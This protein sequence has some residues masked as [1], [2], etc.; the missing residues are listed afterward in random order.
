[1]IHKGYTNCLSRITA[2][3]AILFIATAYSDVPNTNTNP[4]TSLG[5]IASLSYTGSVSPKFAYNLLGEGG[6]YHLRAN[7]TVGFAL[8]D[9]NRFKITTEYLAQDITY[10]FFSGNSQQWVHQT[11]VGAGYQHD[12]NMRF[13]PQFDVSGYY[14]Y[15]PSK[16]LSIVSGLYVNPMGAPINFIDNRRI[17]GSA[18]S[19]GEAGFSLHPWLSAK[20]GIY[21]N[22]D[23]VDYDQSY[24]A[25]NQDAI[26]LGGTA[27]YNQDLT[28]HVTLG[29][30]GAV[31]QPFNNYRIN[32]NWNDPLYK[33]H[34]T[35]GAFGEY[36]EG[37]NTLPNT[38][39]AGIS[40]NYSEDNS[41]TITKKEFA[42]KKTSENLNH[43][44]TKWVND[45][46]VRMPQVLAIGDE[47]KQNNNRSTLCA[48][49]ALISPFVSPML[50]PSGNVEIDTAS[51][52]N[53]SNLVFVLISAPS[54]ININS[55][56]GLITG[57]NDAVSPPGFLT[58]V[59]AFN[60]CGS[61]QGEFNIIT[62]GI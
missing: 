25:I 56:T 20:T 18:A 58:I 14:S 46:A 62:Q 21:L 29:L 4:T 24:S 41:L 12:I 22:Y 11:A 15:A 53:G 23:R 60:E 61:A 52:F 48:P 59:R 47:V 55:T 37:K 45:P 49:A 36:N 9:Y 26:G 51:H 3:T 44:L 57:F 42:N 2:L 7:G 1:M 17:A 54:G 13:S 33:G 8:Y 16:T 43:T 35:F 5:P 10:A 30:M 32:L 6:A 39:N 40:V 50:F 34:W 19:G 28:D 27:F 31:R 38:W